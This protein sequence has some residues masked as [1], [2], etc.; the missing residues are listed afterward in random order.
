MNKMDS[1]IYTY[2]RS[3]FY[4]YLDVLKVEGKKIL[5]ISKFMQN[6]EDDLF[7][8]DTD[9]VIIDI[10]AAI[11]YN[12]VLHFEH[13]FY[14]FSEDTIFIIDNKQLEKLS[15]GLRN[16]FDKEKNINEILKED[17]EIKK[18]DTV[19]KKKR[20]LIIDLNT[21]EIESFIGNFNNKLYG[22]EKFKEDFA[23]KIREFMIFNKLGEHK[24]L[25]LFLM[26]DSGVGKTEVARVIHKCLNSQNKLAKI[27]FG[28]YSSQDALNS[29]I[30]SPRGYIGSDGGELFNRVD[31]SDIG[32]ILIDEFEK[33][34]NAVFNYFLDVLEN[35]KLVNSLAEEIDVNGFIIVFTS[36]ISKDDFPRRIS[37]E[38][39]SRFNYKG[40][41]NELKKEDK[42][43]FAHFRIND[44]I[45]K[46][47]KAYD[48]KLSA[49]LHNDLIRIINVNSFKNMRD[50]NAEINNNFVKFITQ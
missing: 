28:N 22:H 49:N 40:I 47:E 44:I 5:S 46:Y 41:F 36:N 29:L 38:L 43:K 11:T 23:S 34:N 50:L 30:G 15:Y 32:L 25:S 18:S 27:N 4:R 33:S 26:G 42:L 8:F 12:D 31:D 24:I 1:V 3:Q 2:D 13:L 10:S 20:K 16:C 35:G 37:P 6:T 45:G 39:R 21:E 7:N 17:I 19:V 48:I 14:K 9:E